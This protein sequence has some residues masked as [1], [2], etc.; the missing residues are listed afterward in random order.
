[1]KNEDWSGVQLNE[2]HY[3]N[4]SIHAS[5]ASSIRSY[6]KHKYSCCNII[7]SF[8]FIHGASRALDSQCYDLVFHLGGHLLMR[9]ENGLIHSCTE[10][11]WIIREHSI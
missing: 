6:I 9:L 10:H 8:I 11:P 3:V 5:Y 7:G 1:M 4:I 2:F